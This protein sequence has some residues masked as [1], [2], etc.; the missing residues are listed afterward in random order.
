M[1]LGNNILALVE[2][3]IRPKELK[4]VAEGEEKGGEKV[5][6]TFGIDSPVIKINNYTFEKGDILNFEL[7]NEG[8]IPFVSVTVLDSKKAFG[9]DAFPRD[10]DVFTMYIGSK[11]QSTFKSI[12]LD[13]EILNI[14]TDPNSSGGPIKVSISGRVNIPKMFAENCQHLEENTSLEHLKTV[15]Q[16]LGLGLASNVDDTID[17][18]I[19]IQPFINYI[20]FIKEIVSTSYISDDSFQS[21]FIDPY[22]YLNFVDINKIFNTKNPPIS[23]FEDL[24]TSGPI[25]MSE[26]EGVDEDTDTI[27][28]KLF[29]T[30]NRE[31][32]QSNQYVE[33]YN[34]ENSSN[35]ITELHG[36]FR[37]VQ[38]YDDN[39]ED[40]SARLDEFTVEALSTNTDN[41]SDITEPLKGNRETEGYTELIKHKYIGRQDVGQ[42]G[43]G[44]VHQNYIF[45]QLNNRRNFDETQKIKITVTLESFNPSL[46]RYQ[47]VPILWYSY[48]KAIIGNTLSLKKKKKELGFTDSTIEIPSDNGE[49]PDQVVDEF[50]TG[51]YLVE[52]IDIIYKQ[53]IGRFIQKVTLIRRDW[54]ARISAIEPNT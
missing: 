50:I 10:G 32:K 13:V 12:H 39:S 43:L 49:E 34:L 3:S 51:Y 26:S 6:K 31:Y 19:R 15:A 41:L 45:T 36:H 9:I 7:S 38:I 2:P 47:K 11:N 27:P 35:S 24:V 22:Y 21:F 46:Y 20:D 30:N 52:S 44:N 48:D 8:T 40:P 17:S 5:T 18:Q 14:S 28:T 54:P 16:E 23:E 33:K 53:S 1:E 42:E 29:L 25:S 37:E 4:T